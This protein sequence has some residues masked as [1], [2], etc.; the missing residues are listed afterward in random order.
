[1]KKFVFRLE[2]LLTVKKNKEED[3]KRRLAKKNREAEEG[4]AEGRRAQ[5][6]LKDF[7]K[8]VKEQRKGGGESVAELRQSVSHRNALKLALLK[9]GQKL[10]GVMVEIYGV[11]QELIKAAQERRAVEIIREK[12]HEEWKRENAV[13]EQKFIDDLS[14]QMFIRSRQSSDA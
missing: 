3:I 10:D 4:R 12:R 6:E 11:N 8:S 5:G 9:A 7:Q 13:A 14:Q 2:A 1:M